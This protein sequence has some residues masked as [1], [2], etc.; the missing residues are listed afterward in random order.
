MDNLRK[1]GKGDTMEN[2]I[3]LLIMDVDGTLTDGKIYVGLNGELMKAFDV[4]DGYAIHDI[5]VLHDVEPVI[6]TGK[7]SMI[8]KQRADELGIKRLYQGVDDKIYVIKGML[9]EL[10]DIIGTTYN[11]S[12]VAYIGDDLNDLTAINTIN[13]HGGITGCP[14]DAIKKIKEAVSYA[15]EKQGG[16]GAVREFIEWLVEGND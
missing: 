9:Q 14:S 16:N 6:V 4:K 8:V 7:N 10:T 13:E 1:D 12:N 2:N 3:K 15:C 5:L 11:F